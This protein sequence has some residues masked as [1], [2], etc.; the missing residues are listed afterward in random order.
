MLQILGRSRIIVLIV[1]VLLNAVAGYCL[2]EYLIPA[3]ADA[4]TELNKADSKLET[5]RGEIQ[6]LKE[7]YALLQKNLTLFKEL[8]GKGFFNDQGRVAAK[9][10]FEKLRTI[11]GV[12]KAKYDIS[13]GSLIED[14]RASDAGY[15][16]LQSPVSV[17]LD[18][19]DDVDVYS[20]L[21]LIQERFPGKVDIVKMDIGKKENV[22]PLLL[23]AIGTGQPT[24]MVSSKIDFIWRTM[25]SRD[26]LLKNT[27]GSSTTTAEPTIVKPPGSASGNVPT[28][29][30]PVG[31]ANATAPAQ[32]VK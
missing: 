2:Y 28:S 17:E 27:T 16:I 31:T 21:K 29:P 26:G 23:R 32:G 24:T 18:S 30:Q 8:E 7:E 13:E 9:E 10:T 25:A 22:T 14:V 11:S 3:R 20:F 15:V 6:R 19:L 4:E 5:K 12:L 1:L